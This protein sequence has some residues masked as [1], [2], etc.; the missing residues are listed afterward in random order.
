MSKPGRKTPAATC[1]QCPPLT[2]LRNMPAVK[3]K[4]VK[5]PR[6]IFREQTTKNEFG[7]ET[8]STNWLKYYPQKF[9]S[10][11]ILLEAANDSFFL[12]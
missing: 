12:A 3:G 5:G 2:K 1:L 6:S 11:G 7:A 4:M 8:T 9:Y 10:S